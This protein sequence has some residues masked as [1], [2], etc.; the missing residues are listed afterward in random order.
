[1]DSQTD[2][3]IVTA[4]L[5]ESGNLGKF[6]ERIGKSMGNIQYEIVVVD[7]NSSDGTIELLEKV[8]RDNPVVRPN[9]NRHR[10]GL[11]VSNLKGLKN[12]RGSIKIVMDSDL[13][14][15]PEKIG[16]MVT[17]IGRGWDL[18]VM[19]RFVQGSMG[20]KRN[21][22]RSAATSMAIALC[23]IIVP[24]TKRVRDP[25]SGFFGVGNGVKI[26]YERLFRALGNRRGYKVLIPIIACNTDKKIAELP[27]F[28]GGRYWG[29]SKIGKEGFLVPR[30]LSELGKYR[31]LFK[32]NAL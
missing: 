23:H 27:Y 2:V 30:Y 4:T 5:N 22:Y 16:E 11:L 31:S 19:S 7:D 15:P 32:E 24:Q 29:E 9:V 14:H 17:A 18:V 12:S 28:F 3:S 1:M 25:I 20:D 10:E 6:I 13:Q 8:E 21:A 26:P